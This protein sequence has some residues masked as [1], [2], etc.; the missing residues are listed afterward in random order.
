MLVGVLA[1]A[2][3][4][5]GPESAGP[6]TSSGRPVS[7]GTLRVGVVRPS[8]LDPSRARTVDELFVADQLFDTLTR[9][10]PTTLEPVAGV[11]RRWGASPDQTSWEFEVSPTATFADGSA[12]TADDVKFTLDRAA[13]KGSGSSVADLLEP[14]RG[15]K[16]VNVDGSTTDLAGVTVDGSTVRIVLDSPMAVLPV[17]LAN[18]AFGIVPRAAAAQ[19]DFARQPLGSGPFRITTVTDTQ[20]DLRPAPGA[21]AF[22]DGIELHLFENRAASY[23]A[24]GAG[25]VDWSPVP[26]EQADAAASQ[27][28]A[29]GFR[30]YVAELFYGFNLRQPVFADV[31]FREA[32]VR[33]IDRKSI[34]AGVYGGTV[35]PIE[36]L[37]VPDFPGAQADACPRCGF[38]PVKAKALLA[39]AFPGGNVP[40][41]ALDFDDDPTQQAVAKAMQANL[42]AVGIPASLRARPI[43]E[44]QAFA[45]SGQQQL[46]RLGWIAPYA[47]PD[48]FLAP[49]FLSGFPSN[50]TG[51]AVPTVDDAIRAARSDADRPSRLARYQEIERT[52]LDQVPL[53]PI[54]QFRLL[55]VA[56]PRVRGLDLT[57]MGSVDATKV[58]LARG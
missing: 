4:S 34:A 26:P 28:G 13:Q 51:F 53:V 25:E 7:G 24:F 45:V 6:S 54:A 15:F 11:A 44:Y 48:A 36:S 33:A 19:P 55:T 57:I 2:A 16:A 49:L 21:K 23:Q 50:V 22:L 14:V 20:V 56:A 30:A 18:P 47:S 37:V 12:L 42:Q 5:G 1:L 31:R 52:I 27:Y 35:A 8:T 10:N 17:L 9:L 43:A 58:W 38:D 41:I 3:C 40:E 46:F 32:I 39:E 29:R